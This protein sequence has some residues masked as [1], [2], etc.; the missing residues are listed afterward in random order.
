MT[1]TSRQAILASAFTAVIAVCPAVVAS[2]PARAEPSG[3]TVRTAK[4]IGPF[5]GRAYREV[6][7]QLQGTAPGGA[8]AVPVCR[9][10]LG[11]DSGRG[12]W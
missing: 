8:Y 6:E 11:Q 1:I 4:D 7:A 9:R 2:S 3:L 12:T 10:D 5:R